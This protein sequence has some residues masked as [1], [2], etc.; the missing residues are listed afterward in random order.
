MRRRRK[1]QHRL[2]DSRKCPSDNQSLGHQEHPISTTN[3]ETRVNK[4]KYAKRIL[5]I[6]ISNSY[7]NKIGR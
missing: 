5:N 1:K 4:Q 3:V 7:L 2:S 6:Y